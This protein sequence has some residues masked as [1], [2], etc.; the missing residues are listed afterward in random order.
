VLYLENNLALHVFTP[1]RIVVLKL[2]ASEAAISL[3]NIR[4]YDDLQGPEAKIRR[5]VDSNIIGVLMWCADGRITD[6]NEAYLRIIGY[7]RG[8]LIAGRLN[9][10]E[11]TPPEWR[12]AD[13][14]RAT[15]LEASGTAQPYE[16]ELFRKDGTRVPAPSLKRRLHAR[17]DWRSTKRSYKL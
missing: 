7:D 15:Q 10:R 9:W 5:L 3:E 16:K 11:L 13:D 12:G 17:I 14:R 8:D 6:A 2:L 1:D 4:L